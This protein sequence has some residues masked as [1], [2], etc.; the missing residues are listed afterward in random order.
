MTR[1]ASRDSIAFPLLSPVP[2]LRPAAFALL[3]L[4]AVPQ[5][6]FAQ[7]HGTA[8]PNTYITPLQSNTAAPTTLAVPVTPSAAA[9]APA[10]PPEL[11]AVGGPDACADALRREDAAHQEAAAASQTMPAPLVLPP[12]CG[13]AVRPAAGK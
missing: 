2:M 7:D 12:E 10:A 5:G 3:L 8:P 6:A 11:K 1:G 9:P 4:L 13:G